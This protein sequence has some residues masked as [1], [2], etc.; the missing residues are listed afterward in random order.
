MDKVQT[1]LIKYRLDKAYEDYT[2][3][4]ILYKKNLFSQSINRSYYSIFHSARAFL[5]CEKFDKKKHSGVIEHFNKKFIKDGLIEIVYD[6]S[7]K[8]P[9]VIVNERMQPGT[10][11]V[12]WN[13]EK[14]SSGIYFYRMQAGDYIE[15]RKTILIR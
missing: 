5:G 15:T 6:I 10:Y 12:M 3:V 11:E 8:E 14:Y 7:G 2:G 4:K 9:G 13:G 1:D